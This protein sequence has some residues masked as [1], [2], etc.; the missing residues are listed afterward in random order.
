MLLQGRVPGNPKLG[1]EIVDV[2]DLADLHIRAMTSALAAGERFIAA[3][4]FMWM[5]E[6]SHELRSHLKESARKVPSRTM[7]DFLLRLMSFVDPS[8]RLLTPRLGRKIT[9]TS[10]KAQR[11]LGWQMRPAVETLADCARSLLAI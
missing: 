2:R 1:F 9:H 4:E 5:S 8:L 6:I 10:A 11:L 7:P 3:R